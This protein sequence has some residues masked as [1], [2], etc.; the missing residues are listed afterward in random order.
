MIKE[1]TMIQ[2]NAFLLL[3]DYIT[4]YKS[5][6]ISDSRCA[7]AESQR[8][9]KLVKSEMRAQRPASV[10]GKNINKI[11]PD[12]PNKSIVHIKL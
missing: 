7:H 8:H 5:W 12:L 6:P 11:K 4:R 10:L 2:D 3:L 9:A 1:V